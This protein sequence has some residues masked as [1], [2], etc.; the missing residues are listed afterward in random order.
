MNAAMNAPISLL[1][2]RESAGGGSPG[3]YLPVKRPWASGDHTICEIPLAAHSGKSSASGARQSIEYC[4]WEDTNRSGPAMSIAA[5]ICSGVH[6]LK[7]RYRA[8]PSATTCRR[9]STVSSIGT[10][11]SK[12]C[13]W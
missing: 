9:A 3:R 8:L 7:P 13:A 2:A 6:S 5:W 10:S 11:G 1:A 4:G 12:R